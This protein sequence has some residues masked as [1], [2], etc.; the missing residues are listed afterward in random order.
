MKNPLIQNPAL[1][2]LQMAE[3]ENSPKDRERIIWQCVPQD[4][5]IETKILT[6]PNQFQIYHHTQGYFSADS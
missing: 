1:Q 4:F 5:D 2:P 3:V 6:M